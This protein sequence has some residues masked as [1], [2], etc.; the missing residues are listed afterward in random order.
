M[1]TLLQIIGKGSDEQVTAETDRRARAM[2][3]APD[4]PQLLCRP[5]E[6]P[7][8]FG[9]DLGQARLSC[10]VVPIA[11]STGNGPARVLASRRIV[12][13]GLHALAGSAIR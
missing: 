12:D 4:Q 13:C 5:I 10:S 3:L 8:E 9:F 6:Q 1:G 2:Q 11:A 7:G